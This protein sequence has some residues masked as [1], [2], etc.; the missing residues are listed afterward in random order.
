MWQT[1]LPRYDPRCGVALVAAFLFGTAP[2]LS[3]YLDFLIYSSLSASP[4]L[5]YAQSLQFDIED[6]IKMSRTAATRL[7]QRAS[8]NLSS[9]LSI[10]SSLNAN[11]AAAQ[12]LN[13]S[14][15]IVAQSSRFL[16]TTSVSRIGLQ[17]DTSDPKPKERESSDTASSTSKVEVSEE[18]YHQLSDSYLNTLLEKLEAL[19]E[20]REDVDVEYSVGVASWYNGANMLTV[21]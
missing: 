14:R 9:R 2:I 4:Y 16:S 20:E 3:S 15:C 21:E 10:R 17:P 18:R 7:A 19:Q 11:R 13:A 8:R 1:C 6:I 5:T 12:S